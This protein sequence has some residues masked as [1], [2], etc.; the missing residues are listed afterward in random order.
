MAAVYFSV[1]R[2][3]W[4]TVHRPDSSE[5]ASTWQ[6][7]S[8]V[9]VILPPMSAN[10]QHLHPTLGLIS[11]VTCSREPLLGRYTIRADSQP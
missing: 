6:K 2:A 1:I 3:K 4:Q 7:Q 10:P 8:P 11:G 9:L 5:M